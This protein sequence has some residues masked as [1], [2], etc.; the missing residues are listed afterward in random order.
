MLSVF[1]KLSNTWI[2]KAFL[3]LLTFSFVAWG[4]GDYLQGGN[5]N[6]TLSIGEHGYSA[7]DM[8]RSYSVMQQ[9][10]GK[11]TGNT[12]TEEQLLQAGAPTQVL[13]RLMQE[14][15]F[16]NL[17]EKLSLEVPKLALTQQIQNTPMFQGENGFN[18]ETYKR[19]ISNIGYTPEGYEN[20]QKRQLLVNLAAQTF[21][22]KIVDMQMVK[23][24]LALTQSTADLEFITISAND[25]KNLPTPKEED[26]IKFHQQ[27]AAN[28]T[29]PEKRDVTVLNINMEKLAKSIQVSMEEA[30]NFYNENMDQFQLPEKRTTRHILVENTETAAKIATNLAKGISFEELAKQHSIDKN[31]ASEGG[32][33]GDLIRNDIP[34]EFANII[35]N[36]PQGEISS[37][38]EGPLGFHII[39]VEK[40]TLPQQQ[41][42][43]EITDAVKTKLAN[44]KAEETFYDLTEQVEDQLSAGEK[45]TDIAKTLGLSTQNLTSLTQT[46]AMETDLSTETLTQA[47]QMA[48]GEN[49]N[50]I[51][52]NDSTTT[53]IAVNSIT[54]AT[55]KPLEEVKTQVLEDW[56]KITIKQLLNQLARKVQDQTK[57]T[58]YQEGSLAKAAKQNGIKANTQMAK[59]IDNL[60]AHDGVKWM[61]A[62]QRN[63][64][65]QQPTGFVMVQNIPN[66]NKSAVIIIK[67]K[68]TPQ[69]PDE[70]AKKAAIRYSTQMA[71]E[72]AGEYLN[73]TLAHM[74][75]NY[76]LPQ[77]KAVFGQ[78]F[79][80]NMIP[81][82]SL[83]DSY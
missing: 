58:P 81:R 64:L 26:L 60:V 68:N 50:A 29:M 56:K 18:I 9:T 41:L 63:F 52:E 11:I 4:V 62:S 21:Q 2:S 8:A 44:F 74:D 3:M 82:I 27:F 47:M 34:T 6:K 43:E 1:R 14:S 59:N 7:Q 32:L 55:V 45:L 5:T 69:I 42:F 66:S 48:E 61:N 15:V 31:T 51:Q 23:R 71:D 83:E 73:F 72:L 46:N 38:T 24:R 49:S 57:K 76:N 16:L 40:I 80:E 78:G 22:P 17:A 70:E 30:L 20:E 54:P 53:F 75:V 35:F 28:Y 36:L 33:L 77:M 13:I 12:P 25:L 39:K 67:S 65:L 10:I 37:P 79:K 19:I